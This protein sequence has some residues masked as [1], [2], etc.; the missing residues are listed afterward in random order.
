MPLELV[1]RPRSGRRLH[2]TVRNEVRKSYRTLAAFAVRRLELDIDKWK[3]KPDFKTTVSVGTKKWLVKIEYDNESEIGEIY[4]WVDEGTATYIGKD[5]YDIFPVNVDAL[6]FTV[7]N[8]PNT[9][10][11]LFGG[12][13][14]IVLE[15]GN[16]QENEVFR[17]HVVHPGIRPR[18]FTT[19]LQEFLKDPTKVGGFRSVTE[20]AVKRAFRQMGI[21]A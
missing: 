18:H 9:I 17:K 1:R 3:D 12:G 7:P 4:G 19:S 8:N 21:Y 20:A 5:A 2:T 11:D 6:K 10:P 16:V 14:G 15:A 13:L